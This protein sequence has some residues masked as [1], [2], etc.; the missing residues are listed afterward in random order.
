M[1]D[2][3][4]ITFPDAR[5]RRIARIRKLSEQMHNQALAALLSDLAAALDEARAHDDARIPT[6][7]DSH[8]ASCQLR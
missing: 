1:G 6:Q 5:R 7:G 4:L 3:T 8:A 2:V